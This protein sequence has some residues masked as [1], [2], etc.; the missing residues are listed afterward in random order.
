PTRWATLFASRSNMGSSSITR[1]T[2]PFIRVSTPRPI[3]SRPRR[4]YSTWP[5]RSVMAPS[6]QRLPEFQVALAPDG[7]GHLLGLPQQRL[8]GARADLPCRDGGGGLRR[9]PLLNGVA[10][11]GQT[12][13]DQSPSD[14][15]FGGEERFDARSRG[16]LGHPAR[17][18]AARN[19]GQIDP[20]P[21]QIRQ[22][23]D[24]H[25]PF[26]LYLAQ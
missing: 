19:R 18:L 1:I 11:Q 2:S 9:R 24:A 10:A 16:G 21:Q 22:Q 8:A 17:I 7:F 6:G 14:R 3:R 13:G 4:R 26:A 23:I 15:R 25:I 12:S 20:L 5:E